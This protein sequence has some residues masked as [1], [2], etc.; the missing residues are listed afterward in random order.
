MSGIYFNASTRH[1][2]WLPP[3]HVVCVGKSQTHIGCCRLSSCTFSGR[4]KNEC[5]NIM[6]RQ[7]WAF[8]HCLSVWWLSD[9]TE[10]IT[11]P[12]ILIPMIQW[13]ARN[14]KENHICHLPTWIPVKY[15]RRHKI[16]WDNSWH[17]LPQPAETNLGL[18]R[19]DST[20]RVCT[21][22]TAD[23]CHYCS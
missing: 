15:T 20:G 10:I 13:K 16:Q 22:S 14:E 7:Q 2:L 23:D 17:R 4:T 11:V 12:S 19:L 8:G 3:T 21:A 1:L 9:F 6:W 18:L 5:E